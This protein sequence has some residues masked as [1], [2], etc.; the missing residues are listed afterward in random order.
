MGDVVDV[1]QG[2]GNEDVL[3]ARLGQDWSVFAGHFCCGVVDVLLSLGCSGQ[4]G[5]GDKR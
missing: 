3:L 2:A 4:L 1:G 5:L